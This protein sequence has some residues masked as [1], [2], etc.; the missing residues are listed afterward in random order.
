MEPSNLDSK[1]YPPHPAA[2]ES[3]LSS[4]N[5]AFTVNAK[6][7]VVAGITIPRQHSG[8][9]LMTDTVIMTEAAKLNEKLMDC[10]IC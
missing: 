9:M 10:L 2:N 6:L 7:F 5:H 4:N 1:K 8:P 3:S